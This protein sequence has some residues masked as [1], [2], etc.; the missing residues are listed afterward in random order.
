MQSG[1]AYSL[2]KKG[3]RREEGNKQE[4]TRCEFGKDGQGRLFGLL[5]EE[6]LKGGETRAYE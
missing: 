3:R 2:R 5:D 6:E 1:D 4:R